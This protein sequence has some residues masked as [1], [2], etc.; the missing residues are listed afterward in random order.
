MDT[1]LRIPQ[2]ETQLLNECLEPWIGV[3]INLHRILRSYTGGYEEHY[4]LGHN[5]VTSLKINRR[6]EEHIASTFRVEE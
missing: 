3:K 5:A 6:L 2:E 1:T 4:L